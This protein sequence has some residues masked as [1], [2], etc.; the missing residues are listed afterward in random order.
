MS[1]TGPGEILRLIRDERVATRRDIIE[2]TGLSRVTVAQRIDALRNAGLVYEAGPDES[3]GGRRPARLRVNY[4]HGVVLTAVLDTSHL[5]VSA[6]N[7]A[8]VVLARHAEDIVVA[9]G[10]TPVLDRVVSAFEQVLGEA[11][12]T[13]GQVDGIGISVPGPVDPGSARPSQPPLMPGWDDYDVIGHVA[14]AY[15]VPVVVEN[16]ANATALGEQVSHHPHTGALCLIK[17]S[18]GIGC[19]IVVD[20]RVLSGLDG[21]AGDIGHIRLDGHEDAVCTCGNRGC[22]AAVAS[23]AAVA[24]RLAPHRGRARSVADVRSLLQAGDVQAEQ[25]TRQAGRLIGRIAS[26]INSV[27]N[28]GVMVVTGDLASA[29]LLAGIQEAIYEYS[30]PRATRNLRVTLGGLGESAA[31]VG[32][33][34]MVA[35]RVLDPDSIDTALGHL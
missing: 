3:T 18:T 21:G 35:D 31:Q 4:D 16:D 25:E 14:K 34:R 5:E 17:V 1:A 10:P 32:L 27:L 13:A 30:L 15:D 6:G 33:T 23:G 24:A 28:P 20:G 22:L 9:D 19:G 26:M 12:F 8:G 2:A 7:L 11:G 29:P